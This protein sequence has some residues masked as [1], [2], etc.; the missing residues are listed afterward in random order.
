MSRKWI[1]SYLFLFYIIS[2][3]L[4]IIKILELSYLLAKLLCLMEFLV[5]EHSANLK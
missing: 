5:F 1:I 2:G 4:D 3:Y